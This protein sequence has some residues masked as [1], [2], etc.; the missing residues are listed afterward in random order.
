MKIK[1][2]FVLFQRTSLAKLAQLHASRERHFLSKKKMQEILRLLGFALQWQNIDR[3]D[4]IGPAFKNIFVSLLTASI[5]ARD[6]LA[7][8]QLPSNVCVPGLRLV[9]VNCR[10]RILLCQRNFRKVAGGV[11]TAS[12][13]LFSISIICRSLRQNCESF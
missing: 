5:G 12:S 3:S 4:V 11:A 2:N 7:V 1:Y 6:R 8:L 13:V 9:A 10:N